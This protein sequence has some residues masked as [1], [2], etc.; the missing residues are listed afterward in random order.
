MF[1]LFFSRLF[2]VLRTC[3]KFLSCGGKFRL[4]QIVLRRMF[5]FS[6]SEVVVSDFDGELRMRLRLSEHMQRRIFWI[7]Y[8]STDIVSILKTRLQPDM[9]IIDVG[10]NIGEITLVSAQLVG[11]KGTVIS[12][13]PVSSIANQLT[14]NVQMNHLN[15]VM[16]RREG[17]GSEKHENVP[18]YASC[19]QSV[20]DEHNGLA[21]L[22]GQSEGRKPVEYI[23][24]TTLDTVVES[25]TLARLDLIKIDIEGGEFACLLGA[26]NILRIF[27]PMLIVEVQ[28]FSAQKAGWST[29]QL[30]Q[31]LEK[32]GYEFF[33]IAKKGHLIKL[34]RNKP[35]EFQNVFCK[36]PQY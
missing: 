14:E 30:F 19:G 4:P 22:Y 32:F 7:G 27:H 3:G 20:A 10:A 31:Y 8:Y 36:V 5:R 24:V 16:I 6:Q 23:S 2:L 13:E 17:L 15:Q 18:I 28:E 9:V 35:I 34:D 21:S 25:L 29:D 33:T 26:E 1:N 11:H 12:F